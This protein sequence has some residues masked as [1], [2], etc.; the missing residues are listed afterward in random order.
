VEV[1][2]EAAVYC[3]AEAGDVLNVRKCAVW[4]CENAKPG[5]VL[6]GVLFSDVLALVDHAGAP[7]REILAH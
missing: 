1:W 6:G 7:R 2:Q 4:M 5:C 3:R